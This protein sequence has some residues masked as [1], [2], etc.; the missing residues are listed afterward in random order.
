MSNIMNIH[1]KYLRHQGYTEDI[2]SMGDSLIGW[3]PH[4]RRNET[5]RWGLIVSSD[6]RVKHADFGGIPPYSTHAWLDD[7]GQGITE[8]QWHNRR[9][10]AAIARNS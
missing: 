3:L 6:G 5:E 2:E 8:N 4:S 7:M 10:I 9:I 1:E